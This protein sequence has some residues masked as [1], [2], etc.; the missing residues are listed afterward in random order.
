MDNTIKIVSSFIFVFLFCT[1]CTTEQADEAPLKIG[2]APW[3]G[4]DVIIYAKEAGLF[5]QRN[6]DVELV[7]FEHQFD[8]SRALLRGRLD[9]GFTT[10]SDLMVQENS[11]E[12][13]QIILVTN[14]SHGSDGIVANKNITDVKGLAGKQIGAKSFTVNHLILYEALNK[15][16]LSLSDVEVVDISNDAAMSRFTENQIDAAVLWEPMLSEAAEKV[17]GHVVFRTD[18]VDSLVIDIL[19]ANSTSITNRSVDL[20]KFLLAWLDI[21]EA[22]EREPDKVFSTVGSLI[23]QSAEEFASDYSGLK[24]GDMALNRQMF[25]PDNQLLSSRK[26]YIDYLSQSGYPH[27]ENPNLHIHSAMILAAIEK[28]QKEID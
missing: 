18:E 23:G 26:R 24:K 11:E 17:N 15:Y 28:K 2:Y 3:P 7:K 4:F 19:A 5:K 20:E 25:G 13:A 22:I 9:A 14:I 10:T 1:S 6:V 21:M 27:P 12:K 16:G 8:V